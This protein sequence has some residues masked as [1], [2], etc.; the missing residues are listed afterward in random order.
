MNESEQ[1]SRLKHLCDQLAR[2]ATIAERAEL[3]ELFDLVGQI[4]AAQQR[5]IESLEAQI[6]ALRTG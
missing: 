1:V 3:P 2:N 6:A 5:R 4:A